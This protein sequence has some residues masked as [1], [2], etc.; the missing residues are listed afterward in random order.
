MFAHPEE[1]QPLQIILARSSLLHA[2]VSDVRCKW[3]TLTPGSNTIR[4][5]HVDI[6]CAVMAR[7]LLALGLKSGFIWYR[8]A[9]YALPV[10]ITSIIVITLFTRVTSVYFLVTILLAGRHEIVI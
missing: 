2:Y 6:A 8:Y 1:F 4:H 10:A 3:E 9:N 5:F 7:Q